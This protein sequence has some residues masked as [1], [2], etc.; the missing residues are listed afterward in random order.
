MYKLVSPEFEQT[1]L[2]DVHLTKTYLI[3]DMFFCIIKYMR[4]YIINFI[5]F[6]KERI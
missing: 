1:I 6:L 3:L 2:E 5:I 4:I